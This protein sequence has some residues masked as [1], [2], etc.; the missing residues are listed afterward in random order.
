MNDDPIP[1]VAAQHPPQPHGAADHDEPAGSS[2][3]T[4]SAA[5]GEPGTARAAEVAAERRELRRARRQVRRKHKE[6]LAKKLEFL[7]HL[8]KSLDMVVYA[9]FCTLYYM[10]CSL[11]FLLMRSLPHYALISPKATKLI[12]P[13]HRPFVFAIL[14]PTIFCMAMHLLYSLP[15]AGEATRGYL[16]GGAIID[17]VG[18]RPPTWKMGLLYFDVMI[19]VLQC[20]MLAVL[21]EKQRVGRGIG[22]SSLRALSGRAALARAGENTQTEQE[23]EETENAAQDHDAEE[24]GVLR[25]EPQTLGDDDD[26]INETQ[27]LTAEGDSGRRQDERIAIGHSQLRGNADL[28]DVLQSG[29]GMLGTFRAVHAV[30]TAWNDAE[31]GALASFREYAAAV[32]GA[33]AADRRARLANMNMAG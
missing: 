25:D 21:M 3:N 27:P 15:Q 30:R 2:D 17:F 23:P 7:M 16:H 24:R 11:V 10:E 14:G 9:Y 5:D 4:R 13:T 20:L 26:D 19:L 28:V 18:Q 32:T 22:A 1:N 29:N 31:N 33:M 12:L 8:H 6:G